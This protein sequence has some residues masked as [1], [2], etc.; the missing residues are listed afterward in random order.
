[1]HDIHDVHDIL[2]AY[3]Y[4]YDMIAVRV[5]VWHCMSEGTAFQLI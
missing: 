4:Q 1:M 2:R 3:E 5:Y